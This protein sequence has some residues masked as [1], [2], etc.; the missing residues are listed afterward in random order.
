MSYLVVHD[1]NRSEALRPQLNV[2][3]N[4]CRYLRGELRGQGGVDH[5]VA[6]GVIVAVHFARAGK[7]K[8][9]DRD[10][11]LVEDVDGVRVRRIG[12][13]GGAEWVEDASGRVV[14]R[15]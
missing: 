11:G 6:V 8:R 5:D 13:E 10:I 3:R 1:T 12:E 14:S 15:A 2:P 7:R 9:L 4:F